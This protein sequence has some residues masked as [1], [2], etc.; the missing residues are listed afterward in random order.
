MANKFKTVL[1]K[2]SS[3]KSSGKKPSLSLNLVG[4]VA[5][6]VGGNSSSGTKPKYDTSYY[7][8][9]MAKNAQ[10]VRADAE[11]QKKT[12]NATYDEQL[13]EAYVNRMQNQRTLANNLAQAGIRG[14]ASETANLKLATTYENSRNDINK[15]RNAAIAD[16]DQKANKAIYDF[17]TTQE[18]AR[19][20]DIQN[21]EA[22][23]RQIAETKRQEQWQAQQTK[24]A[25]DERRY[26]ATISGWTSI[27]KINKLI[28]KI[29]KSGKD[30]W[31]VKYLRAQR[32]VLEAKK[33]KE[34]KKKKKK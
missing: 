6:A 19:Q 22:E 5:N 1:I 2:D 8:N 24:Q 3:S 7:D 28:K 9:V 30:T 12:T 29:Q 18:A 27:S 31:R 13:R 17:N 20:T 32:A 14:G 25:N 4:N 11:A 33:K 26:A 34:S 10:Q 15:S 21:R 23:D 16:I